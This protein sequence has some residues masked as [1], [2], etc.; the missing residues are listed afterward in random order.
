MPTANLTTLSEDQIEDLLYLA[1]TGE[2]PDLT[3]S[4]ESI[5]KRLST[6]PYTILNAA[7]DPDSGNGLLHMAA[8]N[9]HLGTI[10]PSPPSSRH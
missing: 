5:A 4:I 1:R 9:G 2:T 6:P 3:T 8:A 10:P 7:A